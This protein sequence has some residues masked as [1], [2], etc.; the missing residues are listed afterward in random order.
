[1]SASLDLEPASLRD[2]RA[3]YVEQFD[4]VWTNLRRMG[5]APPDLDDAAQETF[6]I[7]FRRLPTLREHGALRPWL[8]G[9]VRRVAYR[10]RRGAARRLRLTDAVRSQPDRGG[11]LSET[12]QC[13]AASMVGRF[14]ERL[15][16]TKREVFV[17]AELEGCT[18]I[19]I[20]QALHVSQDTV[21][22]RLKAA[23]REFDRFSRV[24]QL[25]SQDREPARSDHRMARMRAV[26]DERVHRSPSGARAR[27][28]ALVFADLARVGLAKEAAIF[29]GVAAG[30]GKALGL[31][32]VVS[33]LGGSAAI[34]TSVS[35][36]STVASRDPSSGSNGAG[37]P[38]VRS[39]LKEAKDAPPTDSG[40]PVHQVEP[41][42][43]RPNTPPVEPRIQ[44]QNGEAV[45]EPADLAEGSLAAILRDDRTDETLS[46]IAAEAAWLESVRSKVQ[47][48]MYVEALGQ[49][50]GYDREF[51]NGT[52]APEV[53]LLRI[54][55]NCALGRHAEARR[56]A[57]H[58]RSADAQR[59]AEHGCPRTEER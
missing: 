26:Q 48:S 33:V 16:P 11:V 15:P 54:A 17:L 5:V 42:P 9:I 20:A 43:V 1:M 47:A 27:V 3:L 53:A 56:A 25:Q 12:V 18:G 44:A 38:T 2:F 41:D 57:R 4:Y 14:L 8:F 29:G 45:R 6:V 28:G 39:S 46:T 13:D 49:A 36:E 52:L 30:W 22:S 40:P 50:M 55:A 23:R 21:W 10:Y 58:V 35:S 32:T 31:V 7:A 59:I 19:E 37:F 51:P 24:V 34:V